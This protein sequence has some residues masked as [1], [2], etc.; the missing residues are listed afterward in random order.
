VCH[1]NH[2]L[3]DCPVARVRDNV[4]DEGLVNFQIVDALPK[5]RKPA[6]RESEPNQNRYQK[7]LYPSWR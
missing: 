5:A 7:K 2:G 3:D 4:A 6:V 1:G